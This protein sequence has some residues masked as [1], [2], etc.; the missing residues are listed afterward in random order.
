MRAVKETSFTS[1]GLLAF[2]LLAGG[3]I[4]GH[5]PNRKVGNGKAVHLA[6]P[7]AS[8]V[9]RGHDRCRLL[10]QIGFSAKCQRHIDN[11]FSA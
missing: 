4:D 9:N 2:S 7:E 10:D 6:H 3:T 1:R 11:I 5:V 8:R